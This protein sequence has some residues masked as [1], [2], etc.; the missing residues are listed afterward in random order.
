MFPVLVTCLPEADLKLVTTDEEMRACRE[1]FP[2][3][4]ATAVVRR[5]QE[6]PLALVVEPA[7]VG[8][9]CA[10]EKS[11]Q[12]EITLR[13]LAPW[14]PSYDDWGR[15]L[16]ILAGQ[17]DPVMLL[18]RVS[19]RMD[20]S[21]ERRRLNGI[22]Q[23]CEAALAGAD[24][25]EFALGKTATM[26]VEHAMNRIESLNHPC[27]DLAALI[28]SNRT[29]ADTLAGAFGAAISGRCLDNGAPAGLQ[30]GFAIHRP[31]HAGFLSAGYFPEETPYSI[32]ETACAFRLPSPPSRDIPGLPVQRFRANL[33]ILPPELHESPASIRLFINAFQGM[34]QP[35]H[36]DPDDRMRHFYVM[37]QTGVG[38]SSLLESMIL[39]DIR[40]GRGVA[41]IDPHGESVDNI[42]ARMPRER[43]ADVIIVDMLDRE[44][45]VAFNMLKWSDIAERD[46]IIDELY[47]TLD[48]IYDMKQT[49]GPIFEQHFRN[50]MKL[51]MGDAPRKNFTPTLLEFIRCYTDRE[52]R[53]WLMASVKD[54]QVVD[55]VKEA[56]AADREASLSNIAPYVTS[57][58]GRFVND[59]TLK[60]I[61][62]QEKTSFDFDKLM[63]EG[64]ICFIKL[65]KGRFGSQV[66]ALLASQ[67]VARFRYSAMK[68][69]DLPVTERRD[70]YLFVDEAHCLAQESF[71]ELLSEA[72]KFRLG[73]VLATQYCS[74]LGNVNGAKDDLLAAIFGNVGSLI[75]F[76]AGSQD[77]ELLA[78]GF[79][80]CFNSLDIM[81]LPNFHGYARMNLKG[82]AMIPFSFR[83]ELD[84]SPEDPELARKIRML[85]RSKYGQ[86]RNI[87]EAEIFHRMYSWKEK[88]PE[89]KQPQAPADIPER[90]PE[91]GSSEGGK[92]EERQPEK[93]G[94]T[95]RDTLDLEYGELG[96]PIRIRN[97]LK[98]S[99]LLTV[100]DI[101]ALS[102]SDMIRKY[103]F[104]L[105]DV[106]AIAR[107]LQSLGCSLPGWEETAPEDEPLDI[108]IDVDT[109][110]ECSATT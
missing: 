92:A 39:Q 94:P 103:G 71:P 1:P 36:I 38:K 24:T 3:S 64:K 77:A 61:I 57:K 21:E 59:T 80:P 84:Q 12:R 58:F 75:T 101:I 15:L 96:V 109:D 20:I 7:S 70:Y 78:K 108:D 93:T 74:Q 18:I 26:L 88:T 48:H 105:S 17:L 83:T 53:H 62:G 29:V 81:S 104:S 99:R 50:M 95:K 11:D 16:E 30:G 33:A 47:R 6:V 34:T 10:G 102:S 14:I 65:G 73:L 79:A 4:H 90:S 87:V 67:L 54:Q 51:L 98:V 68:R 8:F 31:Q 63:A 43:A 9:T 2:A 25:S 56:E 13:H 44:R 46:L 69:G 27:F 35:V 52:F 91:T 49:G 55:F 76:R 32:G 100:R 60:N 107:C 89:E 106:T 5:T 97:R 22:V 82:Q 110:D 72:R 37:G 86:D 23:V 85:S 66:S 41:F 45:P 40:A 19:V 42:L 28:V